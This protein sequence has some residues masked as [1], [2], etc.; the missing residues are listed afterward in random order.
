MCLHPVHTTYSRLQYVAMICPPAQTWNMNTAVISMASLPPSML[1]NCP[2]PHADGK[3][4]LVVLDN[5]G[6]G[7]RKLVFL[8]GNGDGTFELSHS[9]QL[10]S[11]N[12]YS[13]TTGDF[14]LDG[15]PDVAVANYIDKTV[16]I[17]RGGPEGPTAVTFM[18]TTAMEPDS[19]IFVDWNLDGYA[20]L[21]VLVP[22]ANVIQLFQNDFLK[23]GGWTWTFSGQIP[24]NTHADYMIAADLNN[25]FTPDFIVGH[26]STLFSWY[27]M[28]PTSA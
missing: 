1:I 27:I 8:H 2:A 12:P 11:S 13:I 21:A 9:V 23:T 10:G 5:C 22:N 7:E 28:P 18:L 4:D 3:M 14:D 25:D 24:T 17:F 15:Y 20:D 19:A 16:S 26:K 6:F